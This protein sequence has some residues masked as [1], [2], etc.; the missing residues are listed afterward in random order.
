MK[1][2]SAKRPAGVGVTGPTDHNQCQVRTAVSL[3]GADPLHSVFVHII[4]QPSVVIRTQMI[5]GKN[6]A[7]FVAV[8]APEYI[9]LCENVA[10]IRHVE[11]ASHAHFF[12]RV[13]PGSAHIIILPV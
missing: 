8:R 3:P 11:I 9:L 6:V 13:C 2:A 12:R 5:Q 4:L 7:V 10:G 1:P